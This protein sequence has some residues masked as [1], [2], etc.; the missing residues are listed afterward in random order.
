MKNMLDRIMIIN[1]SRLKLLFMVLAAFPCSTVVAAPVK[2]T[3]NP[4]YGSLV[5]SEKSTI[6]VKVS[7]EGISSVE[8]HIRPKVNVSIVI[9]RSGSMAGDK[10]EQARSA[11]ISA[12]NML[13]SDDIVSIVTYDDSAQVLVPATKLTSKDWVIE[14]IRSISLGGNTALFAG[15]SLAAAEIAKF[16]D[17]NLVN[18]IVL[19]SDGLANVGPST[20]VQLAELG[21]SL[22]KDGVAVST[23]GLGLGYNEDLM[24]QLAEKSDGNH[25]FAERATDLSEVFRREFGDILSVV[26]QNVSVT[27][28]CRPGVRPLR[29]IGREAHTYDNKIVAKL[30]QIY[31]A[32]EKYILFEVEVDPSKL[33]ANNEI[34]SVELTYWDPV[35]KKE[36]SDSSLKKIQLT[37]LKS[38]M[39]KTIERP[40]FAAYYTQISALASEEAIELA[41]KGRKEEAIGL[42][43]RSAEQSRQ[44]ADS[45]DIPALKADSDKRLM[46]GS[47][48]LSEPYER[49]RKKLK[50]ENYTDRNQASGY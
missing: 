2:L 20:P 47:A 37:E 41:D 8:K 33:N 16:R 48:I 40:T 38:D 5:K 10:I 35:E 11:A 43:K 34:T 26:A 50:F 12:V 46:Q 22:G 21:K 23:I 9:D 4:G 32:Q 49:A 18:R 27:I 19:I 45:L 25:V 29:V 39:E 31:S 1:L 42:L 30:N 28:G 7:L 15:V 36:I 14:K 44:A 13:S 24:S 3:V 17:P 6:P